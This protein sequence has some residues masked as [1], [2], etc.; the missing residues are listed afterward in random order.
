MA[1]M[2]RNSQSGTLINEKGY[3][4][5][6]PNNL[7]LYSRTTLKHTLQYFIAAVIFIL[8]GVQVCP[9]LESLE[10]SFFTSVV[11]SLFSCM[12]IIRTIVLQKKQP[13][14]PQKIL[15]KQFIIDLGIFFL[16]GLV[17]AIGNQIIY[18]FPLEASLRVIIGFMILGFF[19]SMLLLLQK[20]SQLILAKQVIPSKLT[21]NKHTSINIKIQFFTLSLL[22]GAIITMLLI[23]YKDFEWLQNIGKDIS[24]NQASLWILYEFLFVS[25]TFIGYGLL[26]IHNFSN[27]IKMYFNHQNSVLAAVQKGERNLTV[28]IISNDE[29]SITAQYTNHMINSL[30]ESEQILKQTRDAAILAISSLAETRDNETGAHILRTQEYIRSL[31]LYLQ[32]NSRFS[33][34]LT[35]ETLELIYKSAPLHDIGK[36]GIP[37][38]ILL[39]PGKLTDDEFSIMKK[40]PVIGRQAIEKAEKQT[41]TMPFLHFAKEISETHHEKWDGS[42]YP[43]GL[44]ADEIPLSGRLMALADVYDALITERV[45]KPAFSH[46]KSKAII[47]EGKGTHFDPDIVDAFL[48]IENEFITIAEAHKDK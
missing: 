48:A 37:D 8:Y 21:P 32:K 10:R 11:I 18:Q 41:G 9:F 22:I 40:H 42:G 5:A 30:Q 45:Y 33:E 19:T 14:T 29:F 17:L 27:N 26:I 2:L 35:S 31:G 38:S 44:K 46:E 13:N 7:S 39:K 36:V 6:C 1:Q 24:L 15:K 3:D 23:I 34:Y 43:Y 20:E 25:A 16:G 47:L 12:L 28:P 4:S